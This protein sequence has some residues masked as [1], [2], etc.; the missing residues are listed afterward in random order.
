M[1]QKN[2]KLFSLSLSLNS[3]EILARPYQSHGPTQQKIS[4]L[5]NCTSQ[6]NQNSLI[7]LKMTLKYKEMKKMKTSRKDRSKKE[8][9]LQL[10][11]LNN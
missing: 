11:A 5:I 8:F 7:Q 9:Q 3:K 2:L 10:L 1:S 4:I 6:L